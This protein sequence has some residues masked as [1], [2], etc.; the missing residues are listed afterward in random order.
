MKR[1]LAMVVLLVLLTGCAK[2]MVEDE[3]TIEDVQ[4]EELSQELGQEIDDIEVLDE[5]FNFDVEFDDFEEDLDELE[6]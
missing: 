6:W 3:V 1:I 5:T 4:S 2:Q